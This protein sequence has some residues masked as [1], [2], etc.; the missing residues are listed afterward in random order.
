MDLLKGTNVQPMADDLG[1][2]AYRLDNVFPE[3]M[4]NRLDTPRPKPLDAVEEMVRMVSKHLV[5][6]VGHKPGEGNANAQRR[7]NELARLYV[8]ATVMNKTQLLAPTPTTM[9]STL[10]TPSNKWSSVA[11]WWQMGP[12]EFHPH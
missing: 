7:Y 6:V 12:C 4:H 2:W 3:D 1:F 10:C 8:V 5:V 11:T 9:P